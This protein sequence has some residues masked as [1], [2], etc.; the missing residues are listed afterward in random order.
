MKN[1]WYWVPTLIWNSSCLNVFILST[2]SLLGLCTDC[3][4]YRNV[5]RAL[6]VCA[7]YISHTNPLWA[8]WFIPGFF[9][10]FF[11]GI[12]I[13]HL[14][15]CPCYLFCFTSF[16]LLCLILPVSVLYILFIPTAVFSSVNAY[17]D[18]MIFNRT[19]LH[20]DTSSYLFNMWLFLLYTFLNNNNIRSY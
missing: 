1:C 18:I 10:F 13:T 15:I 16:C 20:C 14:F 4:R 19:L 7:W 5:Y 3:R 9:G 6:V 2:Q 8:P 17:M 12:S 11:G